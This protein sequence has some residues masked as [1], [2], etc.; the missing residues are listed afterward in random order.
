MRLNRKLKCDPETEEFQN[1]PGANEMKSC[2]M[3]KP[4][5]LDA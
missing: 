3:C 1:D 5:K 4:W 2:S